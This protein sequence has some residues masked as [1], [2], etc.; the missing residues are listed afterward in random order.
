MSPLRRRI[1][2][3]GWALVPLRLMIGFGFAAHGYAKLSRGPGKFASVLA[4]IGIWHPLLTAWATSLIEFIGGICLMAGAFVTALSVPLAAVMLT[5]IFTV[6][7]Q[8]GFSSVRLLSVTPSGAVFGPVGYEMNL[9]YLAGLFTVAI[10][11]GG[12]LSVE[13]LMKQGSGLSGTVRDPGR[14]FAAVNDSSKS[15]KIPPLHSE[16]L[17]MPPRCTVER[18]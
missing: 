7:F 5:A 4:A 1:V 2:E 6:H 16:N 9:L 14:K 11:G 8:Y 13:S 10:H 3:R 15:W 17:S 12:K 18:A